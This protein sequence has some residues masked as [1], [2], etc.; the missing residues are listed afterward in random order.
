[1]HAGARFY[2]RCRAAA[3]VR[4]RS[5]PDGRQLTGCRERQEGRR[6]ALHGRA[7]QALMRGIEKADRNPKAERRR[8]VRRARRTVTGKHNFEGGKR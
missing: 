4:K 8:R 2:A 5:D 6:S 1:M 3:V 7:V